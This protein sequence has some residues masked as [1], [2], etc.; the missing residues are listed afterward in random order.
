MSHSY[1]NHLR[2]LNSTPRPPN[3]KY[4]RKKKYK[5]IFF[6]YF[7]KQ[8]NNIFALNKFSKFIKHIFIK[9]YGKGNLIKK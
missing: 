6:F 2:F 3:R 4:K 9:I 7:L 1:K 5:I 8:P